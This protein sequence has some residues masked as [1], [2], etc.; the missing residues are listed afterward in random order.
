MWEVPEND[1]DFGT[2][3]SYTILGKPI[4]WN[5]YLALGTDTANPQN[6]GWGML[7]DIVNYHDAATAAGQVITSS[8]YS[9]SI[10]FLK[11]KK[12]HPTTI[13]RPVS[14]MPTLKRMLFSIALRVDT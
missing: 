1:T 2:T 10:G 12:K 6:A 3:M 7:S 5:S 13:M 14:M 8:S 11:K 4:P 9:P